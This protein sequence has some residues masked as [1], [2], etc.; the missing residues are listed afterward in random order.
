[1]QVHDVSAALDYRPDY[2]RDVLR[3][4]AIRAR[5]AA[6]PIMERVRERTGLV[7]TINTTLA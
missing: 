7:T 3:D 4:G 2:V 1:M 5:A 6:A